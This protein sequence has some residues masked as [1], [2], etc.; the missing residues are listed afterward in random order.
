MPV[1]TFGAMRVPQVDEDQAIATIHEAV[2]R[3]ITHLET[4]RGYKGSEELLGKALRDLDRSKLIIQ[5]KISPRETYDDF[6]QTL[7][8]CLQ[9]MGV[10]YL[11]LMSVHGINNEETFARA[12]NERENWRGI[13]TAM[14]EGLIRHVGFST[15]GD[16]P[17]IIKAIDSGMFEYVNV[18]YYYFHQITGAAVA[19]AAARDMGVFIISPN[20]KGG[21]LYKPSDTL[22]RLCEPFEPMY[23]LDRWLLAQPEVHTL[24]LGASKPS[25]FDI[26]CQAAAHDDPLDGQERQALARLDAQWDVLGST[27]CT[28]CYECMPC[29]EGIEIP[30]ALRLRNMYK[31]F[32]LAEYGRFRYG[33]FGKGGHWFPGVPATQCTMCGACLPKCPEHLNIPRLLF[34]THDALSGQDTRR[35]WS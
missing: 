4:A 15:H 32:D 26:H 35:M 24:S 17:I 2:R 14:N 11:D 34:E 33:L 3:G 20:D 31:A 22:Q 21:M 19:R 28:Q 9:T 10:D 7:D 12:L 13:R 18:H 8:V 27:R 1:F 16:V 29:P 5:S 6:R 30:A 25:D 23:L